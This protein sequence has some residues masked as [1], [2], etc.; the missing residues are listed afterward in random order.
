LP[1]H[2]AEFETA[3]VK[4][5]DHLKAS[6]Q[7]MERKNSSSSPRDFTRAASRTWLT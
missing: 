2:G 3:A 1:V 6:L 7:C 5:H 4:I